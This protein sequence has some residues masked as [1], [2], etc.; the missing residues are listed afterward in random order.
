MA[1]KVNSKNSAKKGEVKMAEKKTK[2]A[3][4]V[5]TFIPTLN[6]TFMVPEDKLP[7]PYLSPEGEMK[8]YLLPKDSYLHMGGNGVLYA[9]WPDK[10]GKKTSH[11]VTGFRT[12]E[13]APP[14]VKEEK[15]KAKEP[16]VEE[17]KT[18]ESSEEFRAL[19]KGEYTVKWCKWLH[20]YCRAPKG[21][22]IWTRGTTPYVI[23]NDGY[24]NYSDPDKVSF[25]K[26]GIRV[27]ADIKDFPKAEFATDEDV[28][29]FKAAK[30]KKAN[31]KKSGK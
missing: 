18:V 26:N 4:E 6:E 9:I 14:E 7:W 28:A 27:S 23:P 8:L 16:K 15:P 2:K 5:R 11:K 22:K 20:R 30:A 21:T 24:V 17:P 31:A 3:K 19:S 13:V 10:N 29:A 25:M 12:A 1:T